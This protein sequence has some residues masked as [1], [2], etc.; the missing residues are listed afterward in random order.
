MA[1]S[2][3]AVLSIDVV[4]VFCSS[5]AIVVPYRLSYVSVASTLRMVMIVAETS[6]ESFYRND[7]FC[8]H[9]ITE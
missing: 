8:I 6:G 7:H 9:I 5:M 4:S 2:V 1:V 3:L